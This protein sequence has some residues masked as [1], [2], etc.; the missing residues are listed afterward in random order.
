M[1][2]SN[3]KNTCK[4]GKTSDLE[5]RYSNLT[6]VSDNVKFEYIFAC[7]V[8]NMAQVERVITKEF[9]RYREKKSR[10]IYLFNEYLFENYVKFIKAHP[11]FIEEIFL[12]TEDKKDEIK[13][14]KKTTPTLKLRG[15][16][17]I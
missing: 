7:E 10:E 17:S 11:L 12:E 2:P 16:T 15:L 1:Q 6:G 4:I 3:E 8:S 13:Y 14:V 5:G 9:R